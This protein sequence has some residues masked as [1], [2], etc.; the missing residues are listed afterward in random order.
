M[1]ILLIDTNNLACRA[2]YATYR[3]GGPVQSHGDIATNAI[4]KW[5]SMLDTLIDQAEP[6]RVIFGLDC[7]SDYRRSFFPA[8]KA[9][10]DEK[11]KGL[12]QQLPIIADIVRHAGLE[13]VA[14]DGEECDDALMTLAAMARGRTSEVFIAT[15]DKDYSQ[16]VGGNIFLLEPNGG[17]WTRAD[18]GD[19]AREYGV[20]PADFAAYLAMI[21]DDTDNIPGIEG[22]GPANAVRLLANCGG[23]ENLA[24]RIAAR[25]KWAPER[26]TDELALNLK[27]TTYRR[28][29]ELTV[30]RGAEPDAI[31]ERLQ[32]LCCMQAL[33][34]W[35]SLVGRF[36]PTPIS[37]VV[38]VEQTEL[39]LTG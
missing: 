2:F 37:V 29:P 13:F 22:I 32:Q 21:G 3:P 7:G 11:P 28:I 25:A 24:M 19:V 17:Q 38:P 18:A 15:N 33:R 5:S 14:V 16:I 12:R 10:R 1:R 27:L 30:R 20:P 23:T 34:T 39:A 4:S 26:A 8:Y 6:D 35:K 31:F 36:G 9:T